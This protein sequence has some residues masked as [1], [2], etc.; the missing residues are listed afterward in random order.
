MKK[1]VF[2][3]PHSHWDREWY[4]SIEDSNTILSENMA[5][6]LTF[7]EQTPNFPTYTFDGQLSVIEDY[8]KHAPE[9]VERLKKL[10]KNGRLHIGPW[11]TQ[12]DTL[13]LQTESIIRN[14]LIGKQG[15]EAF[16]HSMDIGYLPDI[17][18][19]NAYLPSIFKRFGI[20]HS[21][22][23]RGLYHEQVN[24]DLNFQWIA[25]NGEAIPTNN[26]YFGYGPGKFLASDEQYVTQTLLPI[27]EALE[28]MN[29]KDAPL[30]LPAGGD[31]VFVRKNFPK[32]IE[33]LNQRDWPYEF[34]LSDYESYMEKAWMTPHET[35]INGELIA[36]QKSRIHNTIRSQRMDIKQKNAQIEEK[37]YQQLEPLGVLSQ[38]LGGNYPQNWMNS[39]LKLLFDVHA[40]DS[41]GGCNSDETN[42]EIMNRLYK[43][44]RI[45]DGYLNILKKQ[46]SRGILAEEEGVVAFN[47][48]PKKVNKQLSF[49]IFT[50]ESSI[51]LTD[52]LGKALP[53]VIRNQEYIS[54]GTQVKVTAEGE[55]Q[56][57][58]PGYYRT[59][60]AAEVPFEG[61]G[62]RKLLIQNS[63]NERLASVEN[64]K[65]KN[66]F[67]E[68]EVVDGMLEV[69]RY[70][71]AVKKQ[72]FDFENM[73]D[74]G[75]SYDFSPVENGLA[76]YSTKFKLIDIKTSSQES[77]MILETTV[78]V[79]KEL[80]N[81]NQLTEEMTIQTTIRLVKGSDMI[82]LQH[83]M[84]NRTNDHRVRLRFLGENTEG[85]SYGDQGYSLL[86]R[87]N[88]NPYLAN[89]RE[90]GFAEAPQAI[91]PLERFVTIN[92]KEG[93]VALFTKGLKEYEA[94]DDA[95]YLTLFRGVGLL[96]KDD[97]AW[98][99]GRASG[100]NNKVVATPDAQMHGT[101]TFD[102]AYRWVNEE[103]HPQ[104]L[105]AAAEKFATQQLSYQLQTL[106][107]FEERLDRFEL[108]QPAGL[109]N[110]PTEKIG[111]SLPENL[112]VSGMKKA[113]KSDKIILRV[114]NPQI[115]PVEIPAHLSQ[116]GTLDEKELGT[117]K[118]LP[119][120]DFVTIIMDKA[121]E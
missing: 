35:K 24:K 15:A 97:L 5:E 23:Q 34:I 84:E 68:L 96:G 99:P 11:Y 14:L 13:L 120:K 21:I 81:W 70:D 83:Q 67:Y 18:G 38:E 107:S 110:L 76:N 16:G 28:K 82:Y 6:L 89:W 61:F 69:R 56:V 43:I 102:L 12:G 79:A 105:Y 111:P 10:I 22:L 3:V 59:E 86:E 54:G 115:A 2:V 98:R 20:T 46:I 106:N 51:Q 39:C 64:T 17:F 27:L 109:S 50:K 60:I 75:D 32:V 44:E 66:E 91:F 95:L 48:L 57:E 55:V 104:K 7:L 112:F 45:V 103:L 100:I 65:I 78:A 114:F 1:Q 25:P 40:H 87:K 94:T 31:Q 93:N 19:Q 8:L 52:L 77:E 88:H 101:L 119:G 63:L 113:E 117:I 71:G 26:I 29:P 90:E 41:I 72:L 33:E 73:A 118:E 74:A 85:L 53:Q 108:P 116:T 42:R 4:F 47:L 121:G 80:A 30:L 36:C 62:Y 92:E 9:D 58:L 49:I 37:I